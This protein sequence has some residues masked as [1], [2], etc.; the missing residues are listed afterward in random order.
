MK[1]SDWMDASHHDR[2]EELPAR[3]F[4]CWFEILYKV[5]ITCFIETLFTL[6]SRSGPKKPKTIGKEFIT[7]EWNHLVRR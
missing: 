5:F 4:R 3:I 1:D 7:L 6:D 2:G